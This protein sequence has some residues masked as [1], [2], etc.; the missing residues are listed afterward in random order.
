MIDPDAT[1]A[2]QFNG[3]NAGTPTGPV[4]VGGSGGGGG[5]LGLIA[6]RRLLDG[7]AVASATPREPSELAGAGI[8]VEAA[9]GTATNGIN[10]GGNGVAGSPG[11]IRWWRV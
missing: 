6:Y 7:V 2:I 8:T 5:G 4:E 9:G 3:G 1:P 11:T 10:G